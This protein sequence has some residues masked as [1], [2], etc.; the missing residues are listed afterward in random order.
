MTEKTFLCQF[1]DTI[2]KSLGLGSFIRKVHFDSQLS[3]HRDKGLHLMMVFLSG[4]KLAQG[5]TWLQAEHLYC[6]CH[7]V[8]SLG[9]CQYLILAALPIW[10]CLTLIT[11][12]SLHSKHPSPYYLIVGFELPGELWLGTNHIKTIWC[13]ST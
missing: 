5:I 6:V 1:S 7:L 8:L 12:V 9:S 2:T 10:P 11:P 3:R 4:P 13:T